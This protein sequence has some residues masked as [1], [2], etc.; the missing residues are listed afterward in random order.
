MEA[1]LQ[2]STRATRG[3]NEARRLRAAGQIPAVLYGGAE[4]GAQAISVDPKSVLKILRSQSGANTLIALSVDGGESSRVLIKDYLV[5][6]VHQH[7]LHAD[8]Y[9]IAMDRK[10]TVTVPIQLKGE[11][12]GVKVQ[13]G[14]VDFVHREIEIECLPADIPEHIDIDIS[15]MLIGQGVRVR[16][17]PTGGKWEPVSDADLLVVHVIALKAEEAPA[18]DA[19][20]AATASPSEPEVIKKGK[21]EKAEEE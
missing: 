11:A 2:A 9:R 19:A 3:K 7:L 6:P 12:K 20:A 1:T 8:F 16:E 17:L 15:E 18:A 14:V 4:G 5:Q 13:G 10:L 21:T